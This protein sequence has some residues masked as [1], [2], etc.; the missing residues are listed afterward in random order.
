MI[1]GLPALEAL[2]ARLQRLQPLSPRSSLTCCAPEL[3]VGPAG[4]P[5]GT[6]S[7]PSPPSLWSHCLLMVVPLGNISAFCQKQTEVGG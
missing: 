5:L 7:Q 6:A 2:T 4:P 1:C 3:H